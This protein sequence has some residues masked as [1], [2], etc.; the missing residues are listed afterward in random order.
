[1]LQPQR[2]YVLGELR[3]CG[4]GCTKHYTWQDLCLSGRHLTQKV[5][6]FAFASVS[7]KSVHVA[8]CCM[9][10]PW[11]YA[12]FYYFYV[13]KE[14][15]NSSLLFCTL[16]T[17]YLAFWCWVG[18]TVAGGFVFC[19]VSHREMI[20]QAFFQPLY[21][22]VLLYFW[23]EK[24]RINNISAVFVPYDSQYK[25]GDVRWAQSQLC[26]SLTFHWRISLCHINNTQTRTSGLPGTE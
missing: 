5:N 7:G 3:L 11:L 12:S 23:G 26:C 21:V 14:E 16:K 13:Q 2:E 4:E 17:A 19:R 25:Q 18:G 9:T 8:V 20:I 15:H 22:V 10:S 1:M 6:S 24:E